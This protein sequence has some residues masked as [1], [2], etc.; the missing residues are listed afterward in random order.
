MSQ[1]RPSV[2]EFD[3]DFADDLAPL[4][5]LAVLA[6]QPIANNQIVVDRCAVQASW[7]GPTPLNAATQV[8]SPL[9][10]WSPCPLDTTTAPSVLNPIFTCRSPQRE[11][12]RGQQG[13]GGRPLPPPALPSLAAPR[14]RLSSRRK[15]GA[16]PSPRWA[17]TPLTVRAHGAGDVLHL[18][19]SLGNPCSSAPLPIPCMQRPTRPCVATP[20]ALHS[21]CSSRASWTGCSRTSPLC[22][23]P[24][25]ESA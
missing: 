18:S 23:L 10:G 15:S 9:C 21:P 17:C 3:L 5:P 12:S 20:S 4:Q 7:G 24:T 1:G 11:S 6:N 14:Q 19:R 16:P 25:P 8:R 22:S 2:D 13:G